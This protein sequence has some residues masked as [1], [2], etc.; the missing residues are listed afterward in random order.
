MADLDEMSMMLGEIRAGV[1]H[2][3]AWME[4]HEKADQDRFDRLACRLDAMTGHADRLLV[5][6]EQIAPLQVQSEK[7]KR[8]EQ[9]GIGA[10]AVIGVISSGVSAVVASSWHQIVGFFTAR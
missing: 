6:E 10:V 8:W 3:V 5:I 2:A 4:K 1:A 9:R 7:I